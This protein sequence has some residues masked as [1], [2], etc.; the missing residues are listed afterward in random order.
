VTPGWSGP[1]GAGLVVA[2]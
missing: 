2:P 1:E